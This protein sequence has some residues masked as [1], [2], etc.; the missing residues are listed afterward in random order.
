MNL[1]FFSL[2]CAVTVGVAVALSAI[3]PGAQAAAP[4]SE[5]AAGPLGLA[6]LASTLD[7]QRGDRSAGSYLDQATGK[8]I[9]NV[10]DSATAESVRRAGATPR[11][12]ARSGTELK[13][14]VDDW[15]KNGTY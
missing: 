8:L 1:R 4:G 2:S 10:T 6:K 5:P 7:S 14:A 12:V 11:L 13:A 9:V 3:T 15:K